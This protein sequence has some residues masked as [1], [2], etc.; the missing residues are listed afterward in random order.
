MNQNQIQP[1]QQ[2]SKNNKGFLL[3]VLII[4]I[5]LIG[6]IFGVY[7]ADRIKANQQMIKNTEAQKQQLEKKLQDSVQGLQTQIEMPQELPAE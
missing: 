3:I 2:D 7:Y 6:I 5:A 1:C 4:S